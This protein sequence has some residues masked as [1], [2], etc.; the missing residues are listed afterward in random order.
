MH[1]GD[2]GLQLGGIDRQVADGG[3]QDGRAR[4][5]SGALARGQRGGDLPRHR[6]VHRA[7][8]SLG[9]VFQ[10]NHIDAGGMDY[11]GLSQRGNACQKSRHKTDYRKFR[12]TF[13]ISHSQAVFSSSPAV[14]SMA[15]LR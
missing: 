11:P 5:V 12:S 3:A 2:G 7:Q 6:R 8:R 13:A 9:G 4:A 15:M 10:V 14:F 1:A